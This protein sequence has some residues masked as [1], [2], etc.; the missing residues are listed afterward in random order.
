M[1]SVSYYFTPLPTQNLLSP[2]QTWLVKILRGKTN[3][4]CV[5]Y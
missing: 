4:L 3:F 2:D 5:P 1:I